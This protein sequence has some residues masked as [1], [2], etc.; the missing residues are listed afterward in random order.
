MLMAVT[1]RHISLDTI[2]EAAPAVYRAA[3][4]TPLVRLEL[5]RTASRARS[6]SQ[7]RDAAADRILQDSRGAERGQ[8]A[9]SGRVVATASGR[10][11]PETPHKGWRSRH[12]SPVR[13]CSVMVMDTA[14]ATKLRAIERS[15]PRL[16]PPRTTSAGARSNSTPRDRMAGTFVHPFDDDQFISGNGT[17]GARDCR[18]SARRRRGRR[19][20]RRRRPAGGSWMRD[21]RAPALRACLRRG[22]GN[23]GA[24]GRVLARGRAPALRCLAGVVR[25]W[26]GRAF[27]AAIDVAAPQRVGARVAGSVAR[28][29][30][31]G[32]AHRWRT[33]RTSSSRAQRRAR[34]PR[35]CHQSSRSEDISV[36]SRSSRAATSIWRASPNSPARA[37]DAAIERDCFPEA[38]VCGEIPVRFRHRKGFSRRLPS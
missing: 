37:A 9:D 34:S 35:C 26:C 16:S 19:A 18:G 2:R 22:A 1:T 25:R 7:A 33:G 29:G 8:P 31:A 24:A 17:I 11:V 4:R 32:D 13:P 23:S 36:S 12:G 5:P 3:V 30:G 20:A 28:R 14:P 21:A 38:R 6:L 27:G 10:S 15:A